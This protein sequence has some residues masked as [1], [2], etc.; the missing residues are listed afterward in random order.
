LDY[1]PAYYNYYDESTGDVYD[2]YY[3][4]YYNGYY[5][6]YYEAYYGTYYDFTYDTYYDGWFADANDVYDDY[7]GDYYNGWYG[8][9]YDAYYGD[10]YDNYYWAYY[11]GTYGDDYWWYDG[12]YYDGTCDIYYNGYSGDYVDS[13]FCSVD[14]D[15]D[16]W[17]DTDY[18][19]F[20]SS[21]VEHL[22]CPD[23]NLCVAYDVTITDTWIY[24]Y[25]WVGDEGD[26]VYCY[27]NFRYGSFDDDL[28][29]E[30]FDMDGY[31]FCTNDEWGDPAPNV[32]KSC[33]CQYPTTSYSDSGNACSDAIS[34]GC[35]RP[36]DDGKST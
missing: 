36:N 28:W 24:D 27:G 30:A 14:E 26:E 29:A 16:W 23:N 17:D 21:C 32:F 7:Y 22:D 1:D 20:D 5:G 11:D 31:A 10:Y 25:E 35:D 34:S 9:Y 3:G 4:D 18:S 15:L 13:G 33:Y 19:T 6:D 2:V 8:D 12:S